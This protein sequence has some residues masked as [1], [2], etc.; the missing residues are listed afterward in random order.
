MSNSTITTTGDGER[1]LTIPITEADATV[2][3][4]DKIYA[5][6]SASTDAISWDIHKCRINVKDG[7]VHLHFACVYVVLSLA[8]WNRVTAAV[9]EIAVT[10]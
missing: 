9:A 3:L 6:M 2:L 5:S 4:L 7:E 8:D 1:V 10:A